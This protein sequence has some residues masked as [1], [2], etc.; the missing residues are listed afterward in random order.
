MFLTEVEYQGFQ[1]VGAVTDDEDH[2]AI[3]PRDDPRPSPAGVIATAATRR[4]SNG[5]ARLEGA[6]APVRVAG[7][8]VLRALPFLAVALVLNVLALAVAA[9]LY[10]PYS[11]GPPEQHAQAQMAAEARPQR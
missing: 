10:A 9:R 3:V 7:R 5:I 2:G 8:S 11:V 1:M 6:A 4:V